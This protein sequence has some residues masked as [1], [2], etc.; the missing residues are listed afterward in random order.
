MERRG[1]DVE[2]GDALE[3]VSEGPI[4][5]DLTEALGCDVCISVGFRRDGNLTGALP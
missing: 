4:L 1:F 5:W 3:G 2:W